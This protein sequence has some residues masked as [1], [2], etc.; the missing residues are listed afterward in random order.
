MAAS[1]EHVHRLN[2]LNGEAASHQALYV[3]GQGGGITGDVDHA[4]G[5]GSE[6]GIDDLR[7]AALAGRIHGETVDGL[8][9]RNQS[10]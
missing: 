6:D 5:A 4:L 2:G 7:I 8:S 3:P 1:W 9:L 10:R